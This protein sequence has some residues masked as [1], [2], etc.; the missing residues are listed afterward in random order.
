MCER[1][2]IIGASGHGKVAADI[3]IRTSAYKEIGFLDDDAGIK[4]VM[5]IPVVGSSKDFAKFKE[6]SDFFVAIGNSII[7]KK[8]LERLWDSGMNVPVLIHP[9]GNCRQQGISWVGYD[10]HGRSSCESGNLHW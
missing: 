1:L 7:R 5:D 8:L 2:M 9:A 3:A 10:Y 6:N 4:E